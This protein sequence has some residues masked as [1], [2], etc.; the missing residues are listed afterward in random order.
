MW[1][2]PDLRAS[3]LEEF[4]RLI[5]RLAAALSAETPGCTADETKDLRVVFH[6]LK[7]DA[8]AMEIAP[9]VAIARAFDELVTPFALKDEGLPGGA[10][11][12]CGRSRRHLAESLVKL[13]TGLPPAEAFAWGPALILACAQAPQKANDETTHAA[14]SASPDRKSVV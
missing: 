4:E 10:A 7:G 2:D 12:L 14:S 1:D 13:R 6:T 9:L 8:Q 3:F 11:T 5:G